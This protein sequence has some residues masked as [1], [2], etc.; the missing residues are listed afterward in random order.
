MD[1][2]VSR[3]RYR[4]EGTQQFADPIIPLGSTSVSGSKAVWIMERPWV[5]GQISELADS[6]EALTF[7]AYACSAGG[8]VALYNASNSKNWTMVNDYETC[9]DNNILSA[10]EQESSSE[11]LFV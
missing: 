9:N 3:R 1:C 7:S 10:V 11:M 6:I 8:K 4:G 5:N 2:R